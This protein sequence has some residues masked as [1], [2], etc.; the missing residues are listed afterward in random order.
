LHFGVLETKRP[1]VNRGTSKPV[2]SY[3]TKLKNEDFESFTAQDVVRY[4]EETFKAINGQAKQHN[5]QKT[6]AV[7]QDL[8][9]DIF[10]PQELIS[11]IDFVMKSDQTY[12]DKSKFG[13]GAFKVDNWLEYC[14]KNIDD[15]LDGKSVAGTNN[16]PSR[17]TVPTVNRN[18]EWSRPSSGKVAFELPRF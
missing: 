14:D 13:I 2:D 4:F 10:Q 17:E 18:R 9:S 1:V 6:L 11:Y 7:T 3:E 8:L 12:L 5:Y 16:Q 15:W